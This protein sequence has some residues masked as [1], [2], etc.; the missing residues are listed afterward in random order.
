MLSLSNQFFSFLLMFTYGIIL[1]AFF[2]FYLKINKSKHK[3]KVFINI[4]DVLVGIVWG[5][6]GL[7]LLFY[8]N[9]GEFRY[10]IIIAIISGFLLYYYSCK[11][12][13]MKN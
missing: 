5:G 2:S 13:Y 7:L 9:Y 4:I 10:Y 8:V 3:K 11:R 1:A 12:F 6:L